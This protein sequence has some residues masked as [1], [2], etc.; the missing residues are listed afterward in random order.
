MA[1]IALTGVLKLPAT[2][3]S[4]HF[5]AFQYDD[6]VTA[7]ELPESCAAYATVDGVLY[8]KAVT[9]LLVYPAGRPDVSYETPDTVR[10]VGSYAFHSCK[11][12]ENIRL[13][14]VESSRSVHS[15]LRRH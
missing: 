5:K 14:G 3:T 13:T 10:T 6:G 11:Y 7:F 2:I 12:L 15:P 8:D 4:I 9:H 1:G